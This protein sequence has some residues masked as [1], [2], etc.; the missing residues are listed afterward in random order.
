VFVLLSNHG[1]EGIGTIVIVVL[2]V[3]VIIVAGAAYVF[4]FTGKTSAPNT[5][6]GTTTLTTR[7]TATF[8]LPSYSTSGSGATTAYQRY[9]GVYNYTNPIGPSGERVFSNDTV[10]TYGSVQVASGSF[11]FFVNPAN[12]TGFGSG[13]GTMT[14]TTTGFCHGTVTYGYTFKITAAWPPGAALTL[15]FGTPVPVNFTVPL[16]CAGPMQ[17]VDTSTNNPAPYLSTYPGLLSINSFPYAVSEHLS[18]GT[19]YH[20]SIAAD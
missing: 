5:A 7:T 1:R 10:Q 3:L 19:S 20:F 4:T 9:S 6:S 2:V 14:V 11:S 18:G 17:G 13:T 8:P 16:T 15:G 12:Y